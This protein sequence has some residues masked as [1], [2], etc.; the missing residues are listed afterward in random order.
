MRWLIPD[1]TF[2]VNKIEECMYERLQIENKF[3]PFFKRQGYKF[4]VPIAYKSGV[5]NENHKKTNSD[6]IRKKRQ[7]QTNIEE[8]NWISFISLAHMFN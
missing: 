8:K 4:E 5:I 2:Q 1:E 6:R 3:N 7:R